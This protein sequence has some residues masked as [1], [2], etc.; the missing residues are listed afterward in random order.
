MGF[1]CP[2]CTADFGRD[3]EALKEH[4]KACELGRVFASAVLKVAEDD[5]AQAALGVAQHGSKND[6][7]QID[8]SIAGEPFEITKTDM[9]PAA[10]AALQFGTRGP[11]N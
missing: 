1:R 2:A 7:L 3:R 5:A 11:T 6:V 9:L 8:L 10:I 4:L